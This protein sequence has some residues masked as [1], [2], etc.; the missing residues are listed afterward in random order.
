MLIVDRESTFFSIFAEQI[1]MPDEVV[2]MNTD[3]GLLVTLWPSRGTAPE[4]F[5]ENITQPPP[6]W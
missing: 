1:Y 6:H 5:L 3:M 2:E 4:P